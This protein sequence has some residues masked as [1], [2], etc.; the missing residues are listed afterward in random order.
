MIYIQVTRGVA[1]RDHVMPVG[2]APTVFI[3]ASP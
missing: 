1:P 3:M 2:V